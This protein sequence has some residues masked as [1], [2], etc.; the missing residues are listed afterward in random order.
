MNSSL[1]TVQRYPATTQ[2]LHWVTAVL[3]LAAFL[4]GPAGSEQHIYASEMD[5]GRQVHETLGLTVFVLTAVRLLLRLA[6]PTRHV[7][8]STQSATWMSFVAKAGHIGLYLMLIAVPATAV[9]GAWLEGHALTL[10]AGLNIA[11][12]VVAAP[13]VGRS[14]AEV[15]TWLGDT[16][17]WLAGTHALAALGHHFVL[18][19][20][21]LLHML[22]AWLRAKRRE[23]AT[24]QR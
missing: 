23:P 18:R 15:H 5:L 22:P 13:D 10:L 8:V 4:L 12:P 11:P 9:M 1:R 24:G 21:T 19:D 14:I 17:L 6:G 20:D 3:V 16:L 2:A 7:A